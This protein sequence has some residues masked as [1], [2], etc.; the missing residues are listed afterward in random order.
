MPGPSMLMVPGLAP[1]VSHYAHAVT[2]AGQIFVSGLL[3]LDEQ[4]ALVGRDDAGAQAAFIF[5]TLAKILEQ[6]GARLEDVVKL[7]LFVTDLADRGA[8]DAARR[9]A[10]GT[11]KPAS[12]L[13]AVAG[14]IGDG[15]LVEIDAIACLPAQT[16]TRQEPKS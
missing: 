10:F 8:I 2:G 13:V 11:W 3:A 9:Q 7:S 16:D 12:T 1:P 15:T 4:G 5:A 14:L 6:A